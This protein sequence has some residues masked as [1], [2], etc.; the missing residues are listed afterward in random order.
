MYSDFPITFHRV[1]QKLYVWYHTSINK[2][3]CEIY[4]IKQLEISDCTSENMATE[5][6]LLDGG[7]ECDP[8]MWLQLY[9]WQKMKWQKYQVYTGWRANGMLT[10]I[11]SWMIVSQSIVICSYE[12]LSEKKRHACIS[13]SMS[14]L[15]LSKSSRSY[16]GVLSFCTKC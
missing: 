16:I 15:C 7:K 4:V 3:S 8:W 14:Y 11:T 5:W 12:E 10:S 2:T 13:A 9:L 6:C 1:C